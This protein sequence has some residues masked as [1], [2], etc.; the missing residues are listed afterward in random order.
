[1]H[2]WWKAPLKK[3]GKPAP[4]PSM[5]SSVSLIYRGA[6][7]TPKTSLPKCCASRTLC[8]ICVCMYSC[9]YL[10]MYVCMYVCMC[11]CVCVSL[12]YKCAQNTPKTLL[13]ARHVIHTYTY[14]YTHALT[15]TKSFLGSHTYTQIHTY[16]HR[17][18]LFTRNFFCIEMR[19]YFLNRKFMSDEVLP[20]WW[21]RSVVEVELLSQLCMYVCMYVCMCVYVCMYI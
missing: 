7:N 16:T 12:I 14:I 5:P 6:R 11:V 15:T 1:M 21:G 19:A 2:T 18:K 20:S 10:C 8:S 4:V 9:M 17:N 3:W 13:L